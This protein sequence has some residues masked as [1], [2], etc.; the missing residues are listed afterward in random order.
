MPSPRAPRHAPAGGTLRTGDHHT[1]KAPTRTP[2]TVVA[3]SHRLQ[4][5]DLTLAVLLNEHQLLTTDQITATLFSSP[6]TAAHRLRALRRTGFID[7][8]IRRRAGRPPQTCWISGP[9]SARYAALADDQPPPT[10]KALR[11]VQDRI[12]ANPQLTHLIGA[13]QFQIDLLAHARTHPDTRLAR[14]WSTRRANAAYGRTIRP[15]AHGIWAASG[16]QV[17]YWLEHDESTE[18]LTRLVLKLGAYQKL[19]AEGGPGYPLLFWL[20]SRRRETTLHYRLADHDTHG[21]IVA[22]AA[23]DSLDGHSPAGPIWRLFG[24]GRHRLP[25]AELPNQPGRPGS[26]NPP[27]QAADDPLHQ[28]R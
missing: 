25:L 27:L 1:T 2:P 12:L 19:R 14:W 15:D 20:A 23:R 6:V 10:A 11:D 7:R 3:I 9:L 26:L 21:V 17:G 18:P 13:N 4:P 22:T 24:N 28:L 8:L 16:Q 5:R